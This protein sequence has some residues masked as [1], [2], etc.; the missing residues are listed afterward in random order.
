[1]PRAMRLRAGALGARAPQS[2]ARGGAR[3]ERGGGMAGAGGRG[4]G[5]AG[6]GAPAAGRR[7]PAGGS[8]RPAEARGGGAE[9]GARAVAGLAGLVD[10]R[11][12]G[13]MQAA[14]GRILAHLQEANGLLGAFNDFSEQRYAAVAPDLAEAT[15]ALTGMQTDL[16]AILKKITAMKRKIEERSPGLLQRC[17][18]E[19]AAA[20]AATGPAAAREAAPGETTPPG[21][22][23]SADGREGGGLKARAVED[24]L[25]GTGN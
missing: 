2:G 9:A 24:V 21:G 3:A 1:M 16:Y 17:D 15:Q 22:S 5:S 10:S 12:V 7:A 6:D 11:R 14:Q 20:A 19:L 25:Q 23:A 8:G 18:S 4:G 13:E